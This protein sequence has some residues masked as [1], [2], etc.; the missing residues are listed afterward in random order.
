M[1]YRSTLVTRAAGIAGASER[2]WVR[3]AKRVDTIVD[4]ARKSVF[5]DRTYLTLFHVTR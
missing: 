4:A 2:G 3:R 5:R 1:K